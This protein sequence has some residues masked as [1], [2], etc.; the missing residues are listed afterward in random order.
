MNTYKLVNKDGCVMK[1]IDAMSFKE[2]RK[3]FFSEY[4]GNYKITCLKE[5]VNVNVRL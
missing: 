1:R 4:A 2:A 5:S 3:I